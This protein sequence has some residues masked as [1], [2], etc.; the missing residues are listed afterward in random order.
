MRPHWMILDYISL[1]N[2][3]LILPDTANSIHIHLVGLI[4][5]STIQTIE[6]ISDLFVRNT[7]I[8]VDSF[9]L[10]ITTNT[11]QYIHIV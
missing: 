3:M 7:I 9:Q 10:S 11:C 1:R 8:L 6:K 4:L 2:K 5:H